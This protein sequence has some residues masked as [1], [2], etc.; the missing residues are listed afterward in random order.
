MGGFQRLSGYPSGRFRVDEVEMLRFG[1]QRNISPF[2]GL[3]LGGIVS[4]NYFGGTL[5]FARLQQ[6]YDPATPSGLFQSASL[7]IGADTILGPA[8]LSFGLGKS[9]NSTMW[10][11]IGIPWTLH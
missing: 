10:L 1:Y 4:Q 11:S 3:N 7:F 8:A 5:E 6:S 9:G 2:L